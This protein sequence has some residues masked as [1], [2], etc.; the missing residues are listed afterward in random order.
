VEVAIM[1]EPTT[2]PERTSLAAIQPDGNEAAPGRRVVCDPA[3][4]DRFSPRNQS[5]V[6]QINLL[7]LEP[8]QTAYLCDRW[9]PELDYLGRRSRS[10]QRWHQLLR[11]IVVLGGVSITALTSLNLRPDTS[12][13]VL[14]FTTSEILNVAIFLLGLF[15]AAAGALEGSFRWGERWRHFRWRSEL[16]RGEGWS[17]LALTGPTYRQFRTH[18]AAFRT[19]VSRTERA[20]QEES[21]EYVSQLS[22]QPESSGDSCEDSDGRER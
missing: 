19:F 16:L 5:L 12:P 8:L 15:V 3:G 4:K 14:G 18:S 21:S 10:E 7:E 6:A 11:G 17:F 13:S 2:A 1:T 9:L 22:G 20:L